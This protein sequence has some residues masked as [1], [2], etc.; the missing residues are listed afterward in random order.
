M[1]VQWIRGSQISE[2]L[3]TL[4]EK[5][6]GILLPEDVKVIVRNNN[7]GRPSLLCFDSPKSKEHVFKKLLSFKQE[8]RENIYKARRVLSQI[9]STM[10]PIANDSAGNL[11]CVKDGKIVYLLHE[12]NEVEFLANSFSEFLATLY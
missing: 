8:D 3:I 1:S 11:I 9:D 12:T 4:A 7:N 6:Y 10:F 5:E 2:E